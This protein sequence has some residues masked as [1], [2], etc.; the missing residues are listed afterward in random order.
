MMEG[1][2]P[3]YRIPGFNN[4]TDPADWGPVPR[5][6]YLKNPTAWDDV[7]MVPGSNGYRLPTET[8]WEYACRAGTTTYYYNGNDK[9]KLDDI[10]WFKDNSGDKTHKVG[11]KAPNAW[12]LYDMNGNVDEWCWDYKARDY[13][14]NDVFDPVGPDTG[15]FRANRGGYYANSPD[16]MRSACSVFRMHVIPSIGSGIRLVR[17]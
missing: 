1:L 13:D 17:P 14:V 7:E 6:N 2:T 10:A 11:L 16:C 5:R 15:N 4:S 12:G 3:A 9:T 8:Q